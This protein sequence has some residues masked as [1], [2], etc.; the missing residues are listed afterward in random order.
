MKGICCVY[1]GAR[2]VQCVLVPPCVGSYPCF[3]YLFS[4][5]PEG[6]SVGSLVIVHAIPPKRAFV[7]SLTVEMAVIQLDAIIHIRCTA[8]YPVG[9]VCG[10]IHG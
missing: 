3:P 7:S 4:Q 5:L 8:L 1:Y 9:H 6:V 2:L 10:G